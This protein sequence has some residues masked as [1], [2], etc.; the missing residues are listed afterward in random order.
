MI[1]NEKIP[2]N[3]YLRATTV[4]AGTVINKK[5]EK[6]KLGEPYL[7]FRIVVKNEDNNIKAK[8]PVICFRKNAIS[9]NHIQDGDLVAVGGV[10]HH[11]FQDYDGTRVITTQIYARAVAKVKSLTGTHEY[12]VDGEIFGNSYYLHEFER[13]AC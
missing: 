3:K 13:V 6:T 12:E 10:I 5:F 9:L 2:T 4:L 11:H 7:F 8:F 1:E